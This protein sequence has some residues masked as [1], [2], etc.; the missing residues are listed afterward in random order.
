MQIWFKNDYQNQLFAT[1]SNNLS[2]KII[3]PYKILL[4]YY[5]KYQSYSLPHLG[6]FRR[7]LRVPNGEKFKDDVATHNSSHFY[8]TSSSDLSE[9]KK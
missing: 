8:L 5:K 9:R 3:I 6:S 4:C 2:C 7:T 1:I